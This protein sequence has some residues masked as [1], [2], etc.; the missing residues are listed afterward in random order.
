[1]V[2]PR[3]ADVGDRAAKA[4]RYSL[5]SAWL[6]FWC[7][8]LFWNMLVATFAGRIR[9]FP[10]AR[11]F[12]MIVALV[13]GLFGIRGRFGGATPAIWEYRSQPPFIWV[14][15]EFSVINN[16]ATG[17]I[18]TQAFHGAARFLD[19]GVYLVRF[20][21][22]CLM[23]SFGAISGSSAAGKNIRYTRIAIF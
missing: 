3:A 22:R 14:F 16:I 4:L 9:Q 18:A 10:W 19:G 2:W 7:D 13:V 23:L 20:L 8:L 15:T 1:M 17:H 5:R 12:L 21:W 11:L 6:G